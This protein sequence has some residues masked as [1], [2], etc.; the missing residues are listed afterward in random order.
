MDFLD[1]VNWKQIQLREQHG[2]DRTTDRTIPSLFW[3]I[4]VSLRCVRRRGRFHIPKPSRIKPFGCRDRSPLAAPARPQNQEE[5]W[6]SQQSKSKC[7]PTHKCAAARWLLGRPRDG[8]WME[9][10]CCIFAVTFQTGVLLQWLE[11]K[12][13]QL[14]ETEAVKKLKTSTPQQIPPD[15][16]KLALC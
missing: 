16:R 9:R 3:H 10:F 2:H 1:N 15:Q 8:E 14:W 11:K 4:A 5:I 6:T 12:K 7:S 13:H